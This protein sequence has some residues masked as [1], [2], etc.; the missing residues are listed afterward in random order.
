MSSRKWKSKQQWDAITH[1]LEWLESRTLKTPNTAEDWE[2]QEYLYFAN[3][4]RKMY[5]FCKKSLAISCKTKHTHHVGEMDK[6]SI[7]E[8]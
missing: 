3:G 8:F 5:S 1:L 4:T 6:Q 2:Q 7:E